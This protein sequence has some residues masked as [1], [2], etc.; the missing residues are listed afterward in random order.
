MHYFSWPTKRGHASSA[1]VRWNKTIKTHKV[2][3][4]PQHIQDGQLNY[5]YTIVSYHRNRSNSKK[6]KWTILDGEEIACFL[7]SMRENWIFD[8]FAWGLHLTNG[9]I[10]QLGISPM[11]EILKCAKFIRNK[12]DWH[13]YPANYIRNIYDRPHSTVLSNWRDSKIITKSQMTKI[14]QGKCSL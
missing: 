1:H 9:E 8:K 13:G 6:S 14:L 7:K 3:D 11:K 10:L 12:D 4:T 2:Y 5:S